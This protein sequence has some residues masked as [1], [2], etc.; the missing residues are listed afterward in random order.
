MF[1]LYKNDK[2]NNGLVKYW[3]QKINK[4]VYKHYCIYVV[5]SRLCEM[6]LKAGFLL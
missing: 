1:K 5:C 2:L 4:L 6:I 3:L